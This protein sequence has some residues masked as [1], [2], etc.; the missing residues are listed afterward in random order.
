MVEKILN[1]FQRTGLLF[2]WHEP[3]GVWWG[4]WIGIR[5]PGRL[6]SASRLKHHELGPEPPQELLER[7]E[8]DAMPVVNQQVAS[9]HTDHAVLAPETPKHPATVG[10]GSP[11]CV[12]VGSG[13][14]RGKGLPPQQ[15]LDEPGDLSQAALAAHI[16]KVLSLPDSPQLRDAIAATIRSKSQAKGITAVAAHDRVLLETALAMQ[17][18]RPLPFGCADQESTTARAA[19]P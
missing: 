1:E 5:K 4:F 9:G 13:N 10:Q 14:G 3:D 18:G 17:E 12:G 2:R 19:S 8:A 15:P 7:F 11:E 16:V 6:P